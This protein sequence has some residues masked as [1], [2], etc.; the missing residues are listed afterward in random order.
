V[1]E[2]STPT[3]V[4]I[5]GAGHTSLVWGA[6]QE[7]LRSPSI[8]VDLPGRRD[9]PGDLTSITIDDAAASVAVDVDATT[10]GRVVLV[11]HSVAGIILP[12]LAARLD[13]RV[14]HLVFVA[15]LCAEDG[16]VVVDTVRP[17]RRADM[18]ARLEELRDRYR[19]H[20]LATDAVDTTAPTIDD[21]KVAMGIE[22]LN[23]MNQPV[24]WAG[25]PST[26]PRTWVRS[27]RDPIQSRDLQAQLVV[28]CGASAVVDIDAGHTAAVD[29]PA[30]L[31]A[32]L[33]R[34]VDQ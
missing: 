34:I 5:H 20:M 1:P 19:G 22:S 23:F 24:T 13:G 3:L 32:V 15:G 31:A 4:L 29:T 30:E 10:S 26:V 16:A 17:G 27:L 25:V 28:N 33:D 21:T 12:A 9:R 11:G 18:M 8:A 7:H 14:D 6:V 2:P